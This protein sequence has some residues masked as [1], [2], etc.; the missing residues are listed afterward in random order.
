LS[1]NGL[2]EWIGRLLKGVRNLPAVESV[3][4]EIASEASEPDKGRPVVM[5]RVM[6][7]EPAGAGLATAYRELLNEDRII[8][9]FLEAATDPQPPA[10]VAGSHPTEGAR[11]P[12]RQRGNEL[13]ETVAGAGSDGGE[14]V[15]TE[16]GTA[17]ME[18]E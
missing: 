9:R 6:F 8:T 15:A 11:E 2:A 16:A 3:E 5:A 18:A 4:V 10:M 14:S 13:R 12:K 7:R 17:E 1:A